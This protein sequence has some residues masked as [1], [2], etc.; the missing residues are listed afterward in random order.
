MCPTNLS[1]DNWGLKL[2]I[3]DSNFESRKISAFQNEHFQVRN[4]F[5]LTIWVMCPT[6]L[7]SGN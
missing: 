1:S 6:N 7:S 3:I 2:V 5:L 4:V